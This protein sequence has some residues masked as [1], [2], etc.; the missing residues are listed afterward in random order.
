MEDYLYRILAIIGSKV[1]HYFKSKKPK[2]EEKLIALVPTDN[3]RNEGEN[4][5]KADENVKDLVEAKDIDSLHGESVAKSNSGKEISVN[6][7]E[8]END[9]DRFRLVE[10]EANEQEEKEKCKIASVDKDE[11]LSGLNFHVMMFSLWLIS[12]LLN[13]TALLTW[14]RNFK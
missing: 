8:T 14:A 11:Q 5:I 1:C 7:L 4:E 12:T 2:S 6:S 10:A 9:Q 3:T 13:I